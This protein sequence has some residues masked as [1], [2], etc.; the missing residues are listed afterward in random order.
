MLE[1]PANGQRFDT[2]PLSRNLLRR[3]MDFLDRLKGDLVYAMSAF[4]ARSG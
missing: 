4:S 2:E 1:T 3:G